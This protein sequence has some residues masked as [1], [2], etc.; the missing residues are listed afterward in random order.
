MHPFTSSLRLTSIAVM[1]IAAAQAIA[2][3]PDLSISNA[4]FIGGARVGTCNT[5]RVT[6]RNTSM[7]PVATDFPVAY[8]VVLEGPT[9]F[10][11]TMHG[12][13][14]GNTTKSM[15]FSNVQYWGP[16]L[17]T[18]VVA[19]Y[20]ATAAA[21]VVA[22]SNESN[23][24]MNFT[25]PKAGYCSKL[26]VGDSTTREGDK[27][28]FTVSLTPASSAPV[29]VDYVLNNGTAKG[30]SSCGRGIDFVT[31][32][33]TVQFAKGETS[34]QVR[35]DTCRDD[36]AE[37]LEGLTIALSRAANA[38]IAKGSAT[39]TLTERNELLPGQ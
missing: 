11:A 1:S 4:E 28:T 33:G 23:N 36:D 32:Q 30:G 7:T 26:S 8:V 38:E 31:G 15:S 20:S 21:G 12:G 18:G 35:V 25:A 6:V 2:Q 27:L 17:P 9:A 5:L 24:S 14:G 13:I 19:D 22:E 39:G 37:G 16:T 10:S 3:S 29:S 34:K